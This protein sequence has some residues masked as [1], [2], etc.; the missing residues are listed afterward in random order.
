MN[1][2][3]NCGI[4]TDHLVYSKQYG[5]KSVCKNCLANHVLL[6]KK[7]ELQYKHRLDDVKKARLQRI[8]IV[9]A[10]AKRKAL[11]EEKYKFEFKEE[12][13]LNKEKK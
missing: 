5:L 4:K 12:P 3:K 11:A 9:E 13:F 10:A 2:C 7:Y 8:K 1:Q 6:V